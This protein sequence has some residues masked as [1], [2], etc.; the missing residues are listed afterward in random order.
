[1]YDKNYSQD[2]IQKQKRNE[3]AKRY[4]H[5]KKKLKLNN[6]NVINDNVN[7]TQNV[8]G[9]SDSSSD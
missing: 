9:V 4:Y 5:E 2:P 1:V 6:T 3:R 8:S 7:Q